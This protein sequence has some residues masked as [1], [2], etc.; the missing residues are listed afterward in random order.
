MAGR[1]LHKVRRQVRRQKRQAREAE[2]SAR[3]S[4]KEYLGQLFFRILKQLETASRAEWMHAAK[5]QF[6]SD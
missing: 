2:L 1:Q 3:Q 4:A 5:R 6:R